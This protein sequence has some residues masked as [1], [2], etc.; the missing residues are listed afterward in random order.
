M[1]DSQSSSQFLSS[2]HSSLNGLKKASSELSRTYKHASQFYLTRRLGEAYEVLQNVITPPNEPQNE[3]QS[4]EEAS[5]PLAP[6]AAGTA[7]QRIKIWSLYIT[8]LNAVLELD[9][10]QAKQEFGQKEYKS[11]CGRVRDGKIWE[12]V[13]HDGYGGREDSVDAEVVYNL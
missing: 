13:V 8:L 3:P 2:S 12:Q 11:I 9:S 6:I 7:S 1:T 4:D 5:R 10:D